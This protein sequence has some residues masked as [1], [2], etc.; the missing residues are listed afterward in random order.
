MN[1]RDPVP[2]WNPQRPEVYRRRP[3]VNYEQYIES[4]NICDWILD[5]YRLVDS[6]SS[7]WNCKKGL[8]DNLA[9]LSGAL[10]KRYPEIGREI[11]DALHHQD[12]DADFGSIG[13]EVET[14]LGLQQASPGEDHKPGASSPDALPPESPAA[15]AS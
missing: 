14:E 3:G 12:P 7:R 10:A 9:S 1:E 5:T 4:F 2:E 6:D 13:Y 15:P 8:K 11:L